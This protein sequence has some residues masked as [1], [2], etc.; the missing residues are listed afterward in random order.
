MWKKSASQ[1]LL[2]NEDDIM[3]E[4]G[5][6]ST[7]SIKKDAIWVHSRNELISSS[8]PSLPDLVSI[9]GSK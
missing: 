3:K 9:H 8:V 2:S 5:M 6:H 4:G 7:P 1:G